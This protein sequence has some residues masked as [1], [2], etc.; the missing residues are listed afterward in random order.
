MQATVL[1]EEVKKDFRIWKQIEIEVVNREVS[2]CPS[3][4]ILFEVRQF[5]LVLLTVSLQLNSELIV[6][7]NVHLDEFI[8]TQHSLWLEF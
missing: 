2:I 1:C 6:D 4:L 7:S 8:S 5:M 3:V